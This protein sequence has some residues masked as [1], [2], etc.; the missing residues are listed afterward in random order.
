MTAAVD[1]ACRKGRKQIAL[2]DGIQKR[3]RIADRLEQRWLI[4][5]G[6]LRAICTLW[7]WRCACRLCHAVC[8]NPVLSAAGSNAV[9]RSR[10]RY[11]F[12]GR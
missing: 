1:R 3:E 5:R 7:G 11:A 6:L 12:M 8:P 9:A 10:A 4:R 2:I